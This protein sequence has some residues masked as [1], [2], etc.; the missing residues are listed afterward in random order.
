MS[1]TCRVGQLA[2]MPCSP[3]GRSKRFGMT[4]GRAVVEFE[5]RSVRPL[6]ERMRAPLF[7]REREPELEVDG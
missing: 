5:F 7:D 4:E 6:G 1:T 3:R 2:D